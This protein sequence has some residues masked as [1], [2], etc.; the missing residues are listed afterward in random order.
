MHDESARKIMMVAK[1]LRR[2]CKELGFGAL[3]S[4]DSLSIGVKQEM[5][6]HAGMYSKLVAFVKEK[7]ELPP[8][9]Y[10]ATYIAQDHVKEDPNYYGKEV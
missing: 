6:E 10:I 7:G 5:Q 3:A 1:G 8:L 9:E 2:I 4:D